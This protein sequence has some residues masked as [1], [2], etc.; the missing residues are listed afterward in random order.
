MHQCCVY[1][2]DQQEECIWKPFISALWT[3]MSLCDLSIHAPCTSMWLCDLFTSALCTSVSLCDFREQYPGPGQQ[4]PQQWPA[5]PAQWQ[6][7]EICPPPIEP[8]LRNTI[9]KTAGTLLCCVWSLWFPVFLLARAA[10]TIWDPPPIDRAR[11]QNPIEFTTGRFFFLCACFR[12]YIHR[13]A[14]ELAS[15]YHVKDLA[16]A[17][18]SP[19]KFHFECERPSQCCVIFYPAPPWMWST[20][21][22]LCDP[23]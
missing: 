7:P 2:I 3:S 9:E 1:L 18:R 17:V 11:A 20:Q 5:Q 6:Q 23:R 21:S 10:S 22:L 15:A 19:L 16:S 8:E 12:Q 13:V 4:A 14:R